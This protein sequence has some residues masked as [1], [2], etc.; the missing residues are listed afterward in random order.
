LL[1]FKAIGLTIIIV[2]K[3]TNVAL[4]Q[5][6]GQTDQNKLGSFIDIKVT[7]ELINI[8]ITIAVINVEQ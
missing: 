7:I 1:I 5:F 3:A 8:V 6:F 2:G 4:N